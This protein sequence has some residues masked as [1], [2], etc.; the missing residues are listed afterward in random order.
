M[1]EPMGGGIPRY[2]GR[3]GMGIRALGDFIAKMVS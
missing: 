1:F 3:I 2:T